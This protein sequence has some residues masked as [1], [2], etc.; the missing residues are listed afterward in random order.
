MAIWE[1]NQ[2]FCSFFANL[3]RKIVSLLTLETARLSRFIVYAEIDGGAEDA[4]VF[5]E[6][7][8]LLALHTAIILIL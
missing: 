8:S 4:F 3:L 5:F 1:I 2:F 7:L 6:I